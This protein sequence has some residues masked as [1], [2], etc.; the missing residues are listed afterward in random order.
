M[1]SHDTRS[2][3]PPHLAELALHSR[4]ESYEWL[5]RWGDADESARQRASL[6]RGLGV[7]LPISAA[8]W[9]ALIWLVAA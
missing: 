9:L 3:V 1:R 6:M 7:G 4:D 5:L 8:L 2:A